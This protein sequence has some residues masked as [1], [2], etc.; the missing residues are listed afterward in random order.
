MYD[1]PTGECKTSFNAVA[2]RAV[3]A[4]CAGLTT[5]RRANAAAEDR[6]RRCWQPS[7]HLV[8]IETESFWQT[9][10]D[11]LHESPC[12]KGLVTRVEYWRFSSTSYWLSEGTVENDVQLSAL[13]W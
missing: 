1:G 6:K 3:H 5:P 10:F 11:Y 9:K 2:R 13:E 8:L 4:L 12:R 7:R